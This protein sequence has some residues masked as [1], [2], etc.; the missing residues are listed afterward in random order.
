MF[1]QLSVTRN[2]SLNP[3][4]STRSQYNRMSVGQAG[5][6]QNR[7]GPTMHLTGSDPLR[8][9]HRTSEGADPALLCGSSWAT[10]H[11][12]SIRLGS[13][14]CS[15][16]FSWAVCPA[17]WPAA[18]PLPSSVAMRGSSVPASVVG[19]VVSRSK[20]IWGPFYKWGYRSVFNRYLSF[21]FVWIS[22]IHIPPQSN[23][24]QK[25]STQYVTRV[26]D[27]LE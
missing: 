18:G 9:W 10:F 3:R 6:R 15:S 1:S 17:H 7:G 8:R 26:F 19:W 22:C 12:C 25:S 5:T 4:Q 16:G 13:Q 2:P 23:W 27:S 21:G 14:E 20:L 24:S 11:R